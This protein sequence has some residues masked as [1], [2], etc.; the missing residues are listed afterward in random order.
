MYEI[1]EVMDHYKKYFSF[2][3]SILMTKYMHIKVVW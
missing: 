1:Y 2:D 3:L